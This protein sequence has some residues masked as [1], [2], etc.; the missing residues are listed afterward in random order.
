MPDKTINA[1]SGE[2]LLS[3][4]A[5]N[6]YFIPA[7]CGGR[8]D[9]GKCKVKL[10][11]GEVDGITPDI[12]GDILSCKAIL[13]GDIT[14]EIPQVSGGGLDE[15]DYEEITG[16]SDGLGVVI[17]IG[18]TT[19]VAIAIDLKSGKVMARTS[20]L[21]AQAVFG[22]DVISRINACEDGKL[23]DL[24]KLIVNQCNLLAGKVS[25]GRKVDEMVITANT[26]MLHI[27][28]GVN[29]QSIG[30]SPFTPVF[31]ESK[32]GSG[33]EWGINAEKLTLLPSVSG[34]IGAD[35]VCG[36][37]ATKLGQTRTELFIDV[38]TNG[39]IVLS[40]NGKLF[41]TST[42]MGPALEGACIE[43]GSGGVI[44]AIDKL[45]NDGDKLKISTIKNAPPKSICG[46]GLID[47]IALLLDEE[48]I[49]ETGAFNEDSNSKFI[50]RLDDY[51]FYL[52]DKVYISQADI[53]QVQL[54]KSAV[55]SGVETLLY[56]M[57]VS[58][59]NIET[60]YIA[61]GLGKYMNENSA[62]RI[63]LLPKEFVGKIKVVGNS[64]LSGARECLLDEERL[65][66]AKA[67]SQAV[68]IFELAYSQKF[69][70][71]FIDNMYF[72]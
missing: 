38:G 8:G 55:K 2:N 12:N 45:K 46:S 21:N 35:V 16:T 64:A 68:E 23:D 25:C 14:I 18:T 26:T 15:F 31:T 39:E 20:S 40:Q 49:D 4:L 51:K 37:L 56:E 66:K 44:G 50:N 41:A 28:S 32:V 57:G 52:T 47:A 48:I 60:V 59:E 53:R 6:G 54:A 9:C 63:G 61:G 24:R 30:V 62:I 1:P 17:D 69:Q 34:Y 19:V 27:F 33:K 58:L 11:S 5:K 43:C 29:P 65:N 67:I 13:K 7:S 42:A 36:I 71:S 72:K 10:A 70:N 22:A 3:V